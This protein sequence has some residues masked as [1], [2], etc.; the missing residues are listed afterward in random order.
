MPDKDDKDNKDSK[1]DRTRESGSGAGTGGG[2]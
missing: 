2:R 1:D